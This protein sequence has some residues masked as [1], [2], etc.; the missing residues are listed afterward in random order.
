MEVRHGISTPSTVMVVGPA[1][2]GKTELVFRMLSSG[3]VFL[4]APTRVM[5]HYGAWQNRFREVEA[6]DP[7][8]EFV[9]GLP[10]HNDLPSGTEHT[11]MVIDDLMEEV[12]NSKTA[13]DIFT[14]HSHHRNMTVLFLVQKLYG[15]THNTRVISQNAHIMVLFKNP[16]DASSVQTLGRQMYPGNPRFLY[17]AYHD[18]TKTPHS[19]LVV[20][21]HQKTDDRMRVVGNLFEEANPTVY[22][23]KRDTHNH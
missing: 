12:S 10:T 3:E 20:N 7:R 2:C 1:G 16:R 6:S 18:A 11:V 14:K 22:I 4:P 9:E 15:R 19:Y 21:S 5:Y 8:F 23:P 13:M 17:A